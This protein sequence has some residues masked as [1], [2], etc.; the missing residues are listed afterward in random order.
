MGLAAGISVTV[1]SGSMPTP[2]FQVVTCQ[3]N[4]TL[5]LDV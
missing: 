3:G 2:V 4:S 5:L 1:G